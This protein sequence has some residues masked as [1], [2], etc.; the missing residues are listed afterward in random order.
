[1]NNTDIK[2]ALLQRVM[3]LNIEHLRYREIWTELDSLRPEKDMDRELF[4]PR[5]LFLYG[6]SGVG[7]S[8]LLRRYAVANPGYVDVDDE[9]TEYDIR[10]VVYTD[11]P[12]P[13][14]MSEFYQHIVRALGAPQLAGVRV[15]DVKRQALSLIEQQRVEMLILD[16]MDYI[17]TSRSV[18]PIEA[19]EAIK[20]LTNI[21]NISVVC[22]GTTATKQLSEINFQ[23]FRRFPSVKLPRFDS[24][25]EQ[26][27]DLLTKIEEYIAPPEP[28]GLGDP[29]TYFPQI[30]YQMSQGVLGSLSPVLQRAYRSMLNEN[31]L[32]ELADPELFVNALL[33]AKKYVLGESEE[34]FLDLLN[35]AEIY[36]E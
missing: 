1:M 29:E 18:K 27:C 22:S 33:S 17:L 24:C 32:M 35:K 20:S 14:T 7:K 23:Y 28:L 16:E 15:G 30:L 13:F 25:G 9:G 5:H 31:E 6:E 19:M 26:F 36:D 2:T 4:T 10:P 3:S 34:K 8:T 11:L 12:Q 21:R